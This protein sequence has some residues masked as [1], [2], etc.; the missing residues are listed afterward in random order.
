MEDLLSPGNRTGGIQTISLVT[1][2][3]EHCET[4]SVHLEQFVGPET[5]HLNGG[6][7][8]L[9]PTNSKARTALKPPNGSKDISCCL[10]PGAD[11]A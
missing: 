2:L 11:L 9:G 5:A 10:E 4:Q 1:N 3:V 8:L 7:W 6:N